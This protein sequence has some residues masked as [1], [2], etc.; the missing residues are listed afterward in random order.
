[1]QVLGKQEADEK[2]RKQA[3]Q[4]MER[5]TQ[6][7]VRM[8]EDLLDVS[9]LTRGMIHLR[10]ETVDM[11]A[12]VR[13]CVDAV[14]HV[15]EARD[16]EVNLTTPK[17]P[18]LVEADTTRLE[19]VVDNLLQN[20]SKFTPKGGNTW[21]SLERAKRG[22]HG[23]ALLHVQ[24]EGLGI[25]PEL[26]PHVFDGFMQADRSL[27][28]THGGLGIGLTLVRSL[29]QL[30]GGAVEARSAGI[31]KGSSFVVMLPLSDQVEAAAQK[32][33]TPVPSSGTKTPTR[34]RRV[35]LVDDN[36]DSARSLELLL[37]L[38][39]HDVRV[40]HAGGPALGI[41]REFQPEVILLDIG[42]P[43]MDGYTVARRLRQE[44]TVPRPTI[45]AL[46]GYG[47]E[48]DRNEALD[49]G[50]DVHMTKPVDPEELCDWLASLDGP[51][52]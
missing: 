47:Q 6:N 50:F 52:A 14:K 51:P 2:L 40:A 16:Q 35:L 21:V 22:I 7:M 48:Q 5:Q 1:V 38:A 43:G 15:F 25:A 28:R 49:S 12:V 13:Q 30:H 31:G 44:P 32:R 3:R 20:A 24:D 8:V 26:L 10:K 46:T 17:E 37:G 19:Q 9:R 33:P 36:E 45:V 41:A 18:V 42:L 23:I 11:T 29:V 39:G 27:A 4:M 34:S